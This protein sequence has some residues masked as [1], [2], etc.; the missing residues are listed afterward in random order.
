LTQVVYERAKKLAEVDSKFDP[1]DVE[2]ARTEVGLMFGLDPIADDPTDGTYVEVVQ[3]INQFAHEHNSSVMEVTNALAEELSDG[4]ADGDVDETVKMLAQLMEDENITNPLTETNGTFTP[5]SNPASLSDVEAAKALADEL[6]AQAMSVVD[7]KNSGTPGFLDNEAQAMDSA[8]NNVTMN[9]GYMGDVINVIA[10]GIGYAHEQ[11]RTN[12]QGYPMGAERKFIIDKTAPDTWRYEIVEGSK[13]W[14]GTVSFPDILLGDTAEDELYTAGTL[15]MTVNGT[16]PL[17]YSAVTDVTD[18]QSFEGTVT[19][20]KKT[21]GADISLAGKVASNGTSIELKEAKAELAY[22]TATDANG[23]TYTKFNYFKLN[24][25]LL[26]GKVGTYTIDGSLVVNTYTQNLKLASKGGMYE[27]EKGFYH[28][29]IS[30]PYS[31]V[32]DANI[33]LTYNGV[34]YEPSW[35]NNSYEYM[36]GF[37][38]IPVNLDYNEVINDM[39]FEATCANSTDMPE[40]VIYDSW[41]YSETNIAN[42]GWLPSDL[43]FEGAISRT[44]ALLKGTINAKWLNADHMD[45]EANDATPIVDVKFDGTLEMPE[46]PKML[47]TL[48]FE[49]SAGNELFA[50]YSYDTTVINLS[51]LLDAQMQ[52]L[53]ASITTHNGLDLEI[54]VNDDDSVEGS[55]TK[56][57]KLVGTVEERNG[58]PVIKYIDG[59][60]ESLM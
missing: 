30:C 10:E 2:K 14:E 49:N 40:L 11:N 42:S 59:T 6:R 37:D 28:G 13:S 17:D 51:A 48:Q 33:T 57:G 21:T 15:T 46:R 50:S 44:G 41:G 45:L 8:L 47:A 26:Q 9:I 38:E 24:N 1:E 20:T 25:I 12:L 23:Q 32:L 36:F 5:P 54:V 39:D 22:E 3:S 52:P 7:Y 58:A 43:S 35:S 31:A 60:F 16:V 29:M 19:V 27:V 53:E 34:T 18:S 56:D 55:L 4:E